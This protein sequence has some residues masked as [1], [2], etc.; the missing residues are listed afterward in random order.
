MTA[1]FW[2]IPA[3]F[4]NNTAGPNKSIDPCWILAAVPG[5]WAVLEV[6]PPNWADKLSPFAS[7][8]FIPLALSWLLTS[9][10]YWVNSWSGF[11]ALENKDFNFIDKTSPLL[12]GVALKIGTCLDAPVDV[13]EPCV[14]ASVAATPP[15]PPSGPVPENCLPKAF[16]DP[17]AGVCVAEVASGLSFW[18]NSSASF[19]TERSLEERLRADKFFITASNSFDATRLLLF[20]VLISL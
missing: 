5:V 19:L 7:I 15:R 12:S 11:G 10:K 8:N 2:S 9:F 20:A 6:K 16:M 3:C 17:P 1:S 14:E 18:T 4:N 13:A